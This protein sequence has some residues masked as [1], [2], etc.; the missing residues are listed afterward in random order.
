M[1]ALYNP[2]FPGPHWPILH[3]SPQQ[4]HGE[5]TFSFI[6]LDSVVA[7]HVVECVNPMAVVDLVIC[8]AVVI[9]I[10]ALVYSSP[11]HDHY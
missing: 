10:F 2:S 4:Q 9:F 5:I 11:Y 7:V 6:A 3:Q 8:I 1:S